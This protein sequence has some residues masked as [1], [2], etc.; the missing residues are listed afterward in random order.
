MHHDRKKSFAILI[1]EHSQQLATLLFERLAIAKDAVH[2][3]AFPVILTV[4]D[5]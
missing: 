3:A 5:T 1:D 4:T 2:S